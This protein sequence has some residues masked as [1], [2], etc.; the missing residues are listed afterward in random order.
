MPR[1]NL[2]LPLMLIIAMPA[3]AQNRATDAGARG[4]L[5]LVAN[6][7]DHT[8]G[9][10]D[11]LAGR[12][13]ATIDFNGVTG[14]ELVASPDGRFAYVPIYGNSGVGQPGT[15]GSNLVV[16]DL[17]A[18]KIAGNVDFGHGVR[19]HCI[20]IGP[21]DGLLYVTTELDQAITVID[22]RTLK[23]AGKIPTTQ[24]ESHMLAISRDGRRGY[25]VNVGP[26]N[27]SVLDLEN[28]KSIVVIPVAPRI[29]RIALSIDDRLVFTAD[30]SQPQLA[31]IDTA[32]NK[33]K[34]PI[35]LP[36]IGYGA[37]PT[38]DGRWLVVPIHTGNQVVIV[39]LDTMKV[40]RSIA[41][42]AVPQEV[43]IAPDGHAAYVSCDVSH[44]VAVIRTSDWTVE[45]L[46][47]VGPSADGLAWAA[48][49]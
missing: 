48:A 26:G 45:K 12:Q 8:V 42:P 20:R 24:P 10:I 36:G 6:K 28:R 43:L 21:Q 22:P 7:G 47:D 13:I 9:L 41:V 34:N 17:V 4:A 49:K 16:V 44:K 40:A 23:I 19:P 14:H 37:A 31:V 39:D 46:I 15:D 29:Q 27:V 5:L 18:R 2:L 3:P 1:M 33:L 35:P 32:T 30:Q 11:P 38:P 25:A